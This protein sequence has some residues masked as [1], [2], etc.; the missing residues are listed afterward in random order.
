MKAALLH[1]AIT[2]LIANKGLPAEAAQKRMA[3][4]SRNPKSVNHSQE[5]RASAVLLLLYPKAD[6]WHLALIKRNSYKGSHRAQIS[7]PGGKKEEKDSD[8]E[9]CAIRETFEEVGV[10]C[11]PEQILGALSS[12]YIPISNFK[13]YPYI[14][15]CKS[16]PHFVADPHEV[17]HIIELPLSTILDAR[18]KGQREID[19]QGHHIST[20]TYELE[21]D[22]IWGATAMILSEFAE[23]LKG[24]DYS[25]LCTTKI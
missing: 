5:P 7:L 17:K 21:D 10:L 22:Y 15:L 4:S 12:L 20:P 6:E 13:V 16:T 8:L 14:A 1:Q 3:P 23:L 25:I 19:S 2:Q 24:I 9:A 11:R 18:H